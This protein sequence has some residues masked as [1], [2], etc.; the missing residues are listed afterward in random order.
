MMTRGTL[1]GCPSEDEAVAAREAAEESRMDETVR[2]IIDLGI[3][4]AEIVEP[5]Y[6][7]RRVFEQIK[8][9]LDSD[10]NNLFALIDLGDVQVDG[11]DITVNRFEIEEI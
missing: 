9:E 7:Q 8:G 1:P 11:Y 5:V 3:I 6:I 4:R 2:V 10:Y